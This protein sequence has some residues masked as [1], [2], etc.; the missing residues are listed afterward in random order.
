MAVF[1]RGGSPQHINGTTAVATL[2]KWPVEA[3]PTV[4]FTIHN[5]HASAALEVFLTKAAADLGAGN[6]ILIAAGMGWQAPVEII[7]FWTI[8]ASAV[9]FRAL[10]V[11]RP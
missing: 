11:S 2:E 5:L 9:P 3:G 8:S 4:D 6:G 7:E 10:A 1:V